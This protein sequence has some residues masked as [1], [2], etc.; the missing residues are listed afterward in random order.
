MIMNIT[1]DTTQFDQDS[2]NM[3][4]DWHS[5]LQSKISYL[6]FK[7]YNQQYIGFSEL[8]INLTSP[9][10]QPNGTESYCVKPDICI[11]SIEDKPKR[12]V[13]HLSISKMPLCAI[14]ILSP[15]QSTSELLEKAKCYFANKISSCWIITP[16]FETVFIFNK[17]IDHQISFG[18]HQELHDEILNIK[19]SVAELFD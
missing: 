6:I 12:H 11:Y 2:D 8:S 1:L 19:F 15:R 4:S 5:Y 9:Y 14:E 17:D 16:D 18:I 7:Y 13:N 3:G 10:M